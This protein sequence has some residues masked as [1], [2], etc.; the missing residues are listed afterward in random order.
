MIL[1]SSRNR[2]QSLIEF[3]ALTMFIL[4]AFFVFQ[5]YIVRGF[6][7]RWKSVGTMFGQGRIYDPEKTIECAKNVFFAGQTAV[8]YDQR[9]FEEMCIAPCLKN[10]SNL[11]ACTFCINSNC[12]VPECNDP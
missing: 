4:A 3:I 5:K 10:G 1:R 8:W 7:G 6:S 9:C 12:L 11:D 2:G